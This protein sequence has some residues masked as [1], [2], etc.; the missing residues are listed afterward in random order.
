MTLWFGEPDRP[1]SKFTGKEDETCQKIVAARLH[2]EK[3]RE[4]TAV[5]KLLPAMVGLR[6]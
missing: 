5:N 2:H 6:V 4:S 1:K 3:A